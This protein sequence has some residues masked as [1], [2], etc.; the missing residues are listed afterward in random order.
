MEERRKYMRVSEKAQISYV[1][2]P[3]VRSKQD[4]TSD[5][6]QGGIRFFVHSFI[7]NGSHLRV[8]ITFSR[9]NITIEATVMLAW[10]AKVSNGDK[11]EVGVKFIDISPKAADHLTNYIR[12]FVKTKANLDYSS[13]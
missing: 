6:S 13:A 2:I 5:I 1:V 7:P 8:R 12:T 4:I 11:Y 9:A 3:V 10:I